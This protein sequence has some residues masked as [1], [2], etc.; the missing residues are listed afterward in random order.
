LCR[1][2]SSINLHGG[3]D[4]S[5]PHWCLIH[6]PSFWESIND[7]VSPFHRYMWLCLHFERLKDACFLDHPEGHHACL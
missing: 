1:S 7:L 3:F 5:S 2:S 6:P 4:E